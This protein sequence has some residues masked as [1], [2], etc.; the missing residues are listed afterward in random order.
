VHWLKVHQIPQSGPAAKGKAIV[1]LLQL[2]PDE[3]LAATVAVREFPDDRY[4]VFATERGTI[5]K[6]RSPPT[7]IRGPAASSPS[8]STKG[9]R[10]LD[11]TDGRRTSSSPPRW[12]CRSASP[13]SEARPMGRATT[14]VRGI[15]LRKGTASWAW[16]CRAGGRAPHRRRARHRQAH[17]GRRLPPAGARRARDHQSQGHAEDRPGH[18]RPLVVPGDQVLLITQEGMIIRTEADQ[19]REIGRSTQG[20]KLIDLEGEDRLVALAKVV[21]REESGASDAAEGQLPVN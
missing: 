13:E 3:K 19:I 5:K 11:V 18:R 17:A 8:T 12:G 10:L 9:D 4:L 1:N 2:S 6:T 14:G 7:A 15:K 16:R 20:V 21:E